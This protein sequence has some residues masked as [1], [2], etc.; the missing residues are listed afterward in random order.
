MPLERVLENRRVTFCCKALL[1]PEVDLEDWIHRRIGAELVIDEDSVVHLAVK[2]PKGEKFLQKQAA[3]EAFF[4]ELPEDDFTETEL[5][6]RN[7]VLDAVSASDKNSPMRVCILGQLPEVMAK[8][9]RALP[10]LVSLS[11]WLEARMGKE[12]RLS[13]LPSQE[14]AIGLIGEDDDDYDDTFEAPSQAP[15]A[16]RHRPA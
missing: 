11:M 15:A 7:A 3:S 14:L 10:E 1:P 16:K 2:P 6:L 12:V 9:R 13:T 5:E 8:R 4:A